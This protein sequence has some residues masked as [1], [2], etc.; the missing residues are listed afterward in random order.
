VGDQFS[1]QSESTLSASLTKSATTLKVTSAASF[2]E[3]G[4]FKI[5]IDS[6]L[7]N[8]TAVSGTTFTV[9]R[10][11]EGTEAAAHS[12]GATVVAPVT[13]AFLNSVVRGS[14]DATA[15]ALFPQPFELRAAEEDSFVAR[16]LGSSSVRHPVEW[17]HDDTAGYLFHLVGGEHM[18]GTSGNGGALVGL[19]VN[20][21]GVGL[22]AHNYKEGIGIK[23]TQASTV[24][25]TTAYGLLVN[26][27]EGSAPGV[28]IQQN[29]EAEGAANAQTGLVLF[30]YKSL[31]SSQKLL[32]VR[33]PS[34]T[35]TGTLAGYVRSE[36]GAL[37]WQAPVT[38]S[39]ADL[40]A[41]SSEGTGGNITGISHLAEGASA[42]LALYD[43]GGTSEKR[44]FKIA[45]SAGLLVIAARKDDGSS[46]RD[47]MYLKHADRS[48]G[49]IGSSAFAGG[50]GVIA[51]G[52]ATKV[53][54]ETPASG[55]VL[56]V[57]EGALK[58]KGSAGTVT[59]VAAA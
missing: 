6:E 15:A 14:S 1:N 58:Y 11:V 27:G 34:G 47:L 37:I 46:L 22:Y 10:G 38:L 55:G 4:E 20:Y 7:L 3:S 50:E 23:I 48:V 44:R 26:C 41:Q 35:S 8:V 21:G 52:N 31:S 49:L 39:G 36:D 9:E 43:T 32:E 51:I 18:T 2:P 5:R 25:K 13:A 30:A 59:T 16:P 19:G 28:W 42:F 24:N 57:Q 54:G 56:Y 33:K 53:P 45:Q 40:K 17:I 12:S 29:N